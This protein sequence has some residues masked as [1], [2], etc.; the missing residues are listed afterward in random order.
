ME[1]AVVDRVEGELAVLLVG[2]HERELVI[3]LG[4]LPEGS[5]PGMWLRVTLEDGRLTQAEMDSETTRVRQR[6]IQEKLAHLL[7]RKPKRG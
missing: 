7:G 5:G 2:E 6:R 4:D 1:R 3:P